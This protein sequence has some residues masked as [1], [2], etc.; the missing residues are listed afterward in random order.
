MLLN[1]TIK[2]FNLEEVQ[3]AY[4]KGDFI[5]YSPLH[6]ESTEKQ[7]F[8][9]LMLNEFISDTKKTMII[10]FNIF[11]LYLLFLSKFKELILS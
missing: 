5:E 3:K 11:F 8:V 6:S 1:N 10:N 2:H 4:A 7:K 9:L